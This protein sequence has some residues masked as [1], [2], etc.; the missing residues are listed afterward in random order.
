MEFHVAV[1]DPDWLQYFRDHPNQIEMNF[2]RPGVQNTNVQRGT[3]WLFLLRGTTKI[4]GYA[5]VEVSYPLPLWLAWD[6]FETANGF[7]RAED[8]FAKMSELRPL[9]RPDTEI[10]CIGLTDPV[11]F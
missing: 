1:T 11:F 9:I 10:G 6:A 4:A 7:D 3:I 8:F 5:K 2:W